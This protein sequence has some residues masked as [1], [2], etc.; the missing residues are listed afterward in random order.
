MDHLVHIPEFGYIQ[1]VTITN[2]RILLR[3]DRNKKTLMK[4]TLAFEKCTY[5]HK[6]LSWT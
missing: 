1:T 4:T 6:C 3:E 5:L 2:K